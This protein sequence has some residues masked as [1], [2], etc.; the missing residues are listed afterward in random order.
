MDVVDLDVQTGLDGAAVV[1]AVQGHGCAVQAQL[2][3]GVATV[4]SGRAE[5][6]VPEADAALHILR[7]EHEDNI[8][9]LHLAPP[10][11]RP[12][13]GEPRGCMKGIQCR[14]EGSAGTPSPSLSHFMG[15]RAICS[16]PRRCGPVLA[17]GPEATYERS[18]WRVL[19]TFSRRASASSSSRVSARL[20]PST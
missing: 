14:V 2:R 16:R 3:I 9:D 7:A 19:K 8:C 12:K 15:E 11:K 5:G 20:T 17:G 1:A 18:S 4:V 10:S 13:R 6:L